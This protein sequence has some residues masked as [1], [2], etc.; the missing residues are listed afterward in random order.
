MDSPQLT[1][2]VVQA[3]IK[4]TRHKKEVPLYVFLIIIGLMACVL[5]ILRDAQGDGLL[6]E[7]KEFLSSLP[8]LSSKDPDSIMQLAIIIL[9][10]MFGAGAIIILVVMSL[11]QMYRTYADQM[12]YSIRVSEKNYPEIYQKV[13]EYTWLLGWKKEPEVYVQ[14][15]N[16]SLNAFTCWV[17]GKVFI[18]LNAEIVD[19]A[20]MEHKDFDTIFFVMAHEFGHAYLHH[21]QLY[22]SFWSM[23]AS[24]IPF[25]GSNIL[26]PM[27]SR[28][29][30]YSADRV[31]QALT[32]GVAQED[33]MMLLA[34][35]RHAYKYVDTGDYLRNITA[36][37]NAIERFARWCTNLV[38]SHPIMPF[39]VRAIL[40]P[41]K[42][43][44]RLL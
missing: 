27:L 37:H 12:S 20:Y 43:S 19:I 18:Q 44:G 3:E 29:R 1:P 7:I 17:P 30:E 10:L 16:G 6:V 41:S 33:C 24:F 34:V 42:K 32:G 11:Y 38:A 2:A 21:V 8:D 22:Y 13:R 5:L 23:L 14:Q 25:L 40:D 35:G 4:K 9:S 28:S 31:A 36:N 39:R 26:L 15:M